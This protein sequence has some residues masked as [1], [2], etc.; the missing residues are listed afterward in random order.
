MAFNLPHKEGFVRWTKFHGKLIWSYFFILLIRPG[1]QVWCPAIKAVVQLRVH[2]S[3]ALFLM[4]KT[5]NNILVPLST[6]LNSPIYHVSDTFGKHLTKITHPNIT[7]RTPFILTP[8]QK[9]FP[10]IQQ[11]NPSFPLGVSSDFRVF[12]SMFWICKMHLTCMWKEKVLQQCSL[13]CKFLIFN[14]PAKL[15]FWQSADLDKIYL[16]TGANIASTINFNQFNWLSLYW[17]GRL[18]ECG[19]RATKC[20]NCFNHRQSRGTE[21]VLLESNVLTSRDH[22]GRKKPLDA[23]VPRAVQPPPAG[24]AGFRHPQRHDSICTC[25]SRMS[26]L[27][28]K[29]LATCSWKGRL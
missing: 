18:F 13:C 19:R 4:N 24:A 14:E 16:V 9:L 15:L 17:L 3:F 1:H 11:N 8:T 21:M 6:N 29:W 12:W 25:K 26:T 20:F 23:F 7:V 2:G 22:M 10:C 28:Q 27:M 5:Q